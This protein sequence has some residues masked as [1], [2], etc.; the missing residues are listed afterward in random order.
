MKKSRK[1]PKHSVLKVL[2]VGAFLLMFLF[3]A[4]LFNSAKVSAL[5]QEG[6]NGYKEIKLQR[7][8]FLAKTKGTKTKKNNTKKT[9]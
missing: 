4:F 1:K 9:D 2:E 6:N 7:E 5:E 3:G 8:N